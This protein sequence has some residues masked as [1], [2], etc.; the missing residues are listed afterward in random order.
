MKKKNKKLTK[1]QK[2]IL[3]HKHLKDYVVIT[4]VIKG[5]VRFLGLRIT[6]TAT[7]VLLSDMTKKVKIL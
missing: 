2:R 7:K 6:D 3:F 4:R 1:K 5:K